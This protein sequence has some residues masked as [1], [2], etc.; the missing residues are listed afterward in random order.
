[1]FT[2]IVQGVATIS[3]LSETG[4]VVT[5]SIRFPEGA[6]NGISKGG[7]ISINGC[8]LTVVEF[9][10]QQATF[11]LVQETLKRTSFSEVKVGDLVHYER[12]LK[13]GDE[14][15][16]HLLSG[17]VDTTALVSAVT[18][19][20]GSKNITF[21][22]PPEWIKYVLPKGYISVMGASLTVVDV[23][24]D[25]SQFSVSLIPETL[26]VTTFESLSEGDQVNI[27]IDRFTQVIVDTVERV[28]KN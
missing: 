7:S 2:G 4:D 22:V 24:K 12:S 21:R 9:D 10:E 5:L 28:L 26:R 1:M 3:Q 15:G 16:G 6:L 19:L 18:K 8:C 20:A 23:Q 11:D 25:Q 27:E 14:L 17:H 13:L